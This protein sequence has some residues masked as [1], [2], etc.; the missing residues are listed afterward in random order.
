MAAAGLSNSLAS[1]G[2]VALVHPSAVAKPLICPGEQ[3]LPAFINI[4]TA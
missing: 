4:S 2:V 3:H 1:E